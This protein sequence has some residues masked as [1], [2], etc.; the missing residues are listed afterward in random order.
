M[1]TYTLAEIRARVEGPVP[2]LHPDREVA[3]IFAEID[4]LT[5]ALEK[6]ADI[7]N[8][9]SCMCNDDDCPY[10]AARAALEPQ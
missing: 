9:N 2:L 6:V 3:V 10:A 5:A 4:R 8:V 1:T 7:G